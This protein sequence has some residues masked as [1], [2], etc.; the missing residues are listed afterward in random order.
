[1]MRVVADWRRSLRV[2]WYRAD[3][4]AWL[5][6]LVA[7]GV[8]TALASLAYAVFAHQD[9]R[10][11]AAR[12]FEQKN[13][14]CLARNIYF[15][16]RGEPA[17]GQYAVGEVTMNRKASRFFPRSVCAVVYEKRAFSWT[18][19]AVLP[20][21]AGEEWIRARQVAEAVY[22][23]RYTPALKGAL[24]YHAT[25]VNPDW[26]KEKRRVAQIGGHIFYK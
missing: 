11:E 15:E 6:F 20:E 19:S 25:Y 16:A 4:F 1:M 5:F 23:Q 12:A 24:Y 3:K 7:A 21:P 8:V 2:F 26:A 17:A 14:D 9:E 13:I 22:Y 18:D 10:R